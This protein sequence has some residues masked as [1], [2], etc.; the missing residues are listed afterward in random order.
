MTTLPTRFKR[1]ALSNYIM[2]F[3]SII[4]AVGVTPVLVR[5]LGKEEYGIWG[6]TMS[7]VLYLRLL[8]IGFGGAT[9]KFVAESHAKHDTEGLRR[10][11]TTSAVALMAPGLFILAI[12]PGL[13][14]LFPV[15]FHVPHHLEVSAIVLVILSAVELAFAIGSDTFGATLTGLQ[16]Y[17]LLNLTLVGTSLAQAIAWTA[18]V[19]LGGGLIELAV[20]TLT[21]SLIGQFARYLL[22]R[23]CLG[24]DML[25]RRHFSRRLFRTLLGTSGWMSLSEVSETVIGELDGLV[26][27]LVAGVPQ[28]AVYLVGQK[29]AGLGL[30]LTSPLT[31]L[32]Y[33]HATLLA[34]KGD[35]EGLRVTV[36]LGTRIALAA[37]IPV[38]L[39]LAVLAAPALGVWAG[40]GYEQ[41]ALVVVFL[42]A[43]QVI[44]TVVRVPVLALYGMGEVRVQALLHA[45]EAAVNLPLSL[46]LGL[47][48][49]FKGV[50]LGT[51]IATVI[52]NLGLLLPYA[53]RHI[54]IS[55]ASLFLRIV[56]THG[57][58]SVATI[59]LGLA[60]HRAGVPD[61]AAAPA[62]SRILS[63]LVAGAAMV[64]CYFVV[65]FLTGLSSAERSR[66]LEL[67]QI[68]L[69]R[70]QAALGNSGSPP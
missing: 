44:G 46:A 33:P 2:T 63:L 5:G 38:L 32:F 26:V 13:A 21:F 35:R 8:N 64:G 45:S 68:R 51:L 61:G 1:N 67:A 49:G 10:V 39:V 22:V 7:A 24:G 47:T 55:P 4:L 42:S 58:A 34:T 25:A 30:G 50:A 3:A 48:M 56:R 65:L 20:A 36:E 60:L 53:C 40:G 69:R 62:A 17:D 16:R 37:A 6:L 19:L 15:L 54:G 14:F 57:P 28:A 23:R 12:S 66:V 43:A 18:I 27:G 11:I 59:A 41:A 31:S 9:V 52:V 70:L 29:L